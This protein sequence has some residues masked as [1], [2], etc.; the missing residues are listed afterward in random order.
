MII[1]FDLN[2]MNE[3]AHT[4][5]CVFVASIRSFSEPVSICLDL[6]R[7]QLHAHTL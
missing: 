4:C 6:D 7:T 1:W 3:Q 2:Q 5:T